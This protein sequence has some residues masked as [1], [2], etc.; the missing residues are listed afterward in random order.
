MELIATCAFGLEKLV[1]DELKNLNCWVIKTE[2]GR[3]T[4]EG[5]QLEIVKATTFEELFSNVNAIPFETMIGVDDQ[6][7]VAATSTKSQLHSEP[8][9][10]KIVKMA[11]VKRLMAQHKTEVLPE[12]TNAVYHVFIKANKDVFTIS[13]DTSGESLHKR[14]YRTESNLAPIKETLAAAM[15]KLS[16]WDRKRPLIDPFCGSGT[17]AIEAALIALNV[18]PG[19]RRQF[20]F[21]NWPWIGAKAIEQGY[22]EAR[23][24]AK[25]LEKLPIYCSDIDE[26]T[27]MIAKNNSERANVDQIHFKLSDFHDLKFNKFNNCTFI[28]NPPYGMRLEDEETARRIAYDLGDKFSETTGSS[29]FLITSDDNFPRVFGRPADKNRKLFNGNLKCYLYSFLPEK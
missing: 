15:I 26:E 1:Y 5:D 17:I 27:L 28:T 8:A 29:M 24:A 14:G 19:L 16:D 12:K 18:A 21:H 3:V 23:M 20:A 7:P 9:I 11:I 10:Q 25:Y 6:F 22:T 4:F 13:L 2:D